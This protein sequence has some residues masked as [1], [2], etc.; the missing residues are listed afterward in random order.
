[1]YKL[2][3]G[4]V[5]LNE[6][7]VKKD[8]YIKDG[9][10]VDYVE[11]PQVINCKDLLITP[12][13]CDVHVHLREP[14]FTNKETILSG[15]K[16]AAKGGVTSVFA[17]PNLKPYPDSI[18]NLEVEEQII[19]RDAVVN[20]Y[21]IACLTREEKSKELS[22]IKELSEHVLAFSDDGVGFKDLELLERGMELVKENNRVICSH[23]EDYN[24]L[25]TSNLSESEAVRKELLLVKKT[26]VKYHF[27]HISTKESF[28][29]IKEAQE[30]KLMVTCEVT[31]HHLF[32]NDS[33]INNDPN[34]KMNPPLRSYEDMF[35]TQEA[36]LSGVATII[37]TDHAPHTKA[38][39]SLPYEKALNGI[40]GL[41][42]LV[43]LVY[44]NLIKTKKASFSDFKK[45]LI[46]NPRKLMGLSYV[47]LEVGEIADIA[48]FDIFNSHIYQ[49]E[50]ILSKGKNSPFIGK[51]LYGFCKYTFVNGKLVYG[52]E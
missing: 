33:L 47:N 26:N 35:A 19:K 16:S 41:E 17:M 38:D 6:E 34:F 15:T 50:E 5:I 31:P 12:G 49:E 9:K 20:V 24:Y 13:I 22:D 27:C 2:V 30:A 23:A 43:P 7:L 52:G 11:N 46:D 8:I 40:I 28:K 48:C 36:L 4:Y 32:L 51:E 29:H 18:A 3:N 21:P 10:I 39:K 45:W 42:T 44:T 14:G 25:P 1:M 37:A